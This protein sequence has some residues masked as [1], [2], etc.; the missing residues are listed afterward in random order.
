MTFL[1]IRD[2][3]GFLQCVL[4][5]ILVSFSSVVNFFVSFFLTFISV[6]KL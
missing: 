1:V 3:T 5:G 4:T 6:S 2:G